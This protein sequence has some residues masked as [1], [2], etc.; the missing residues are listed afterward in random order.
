VTTDLTLVNFDEHEGGECTV[1]ILDSKGDGILGLPFLHVPTGAAIPMNDILVDAGD[2]GGEMEEAWGA[3][4]C[5][6]DTY[7]VWAAVY[8]DG[9]RQV[10]YILPSGDLR[11][12]H[13]STADPS[14]W[15]KQ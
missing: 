6:E 2:G 10:E 4:S 13:G 12:D 5:E 1:S 8:R 7:T 11:P 15:V 14:R 9:G 3:V